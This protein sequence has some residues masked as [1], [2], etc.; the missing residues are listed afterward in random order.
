M[1]Y[2]TVPKRNYC[3]NSSVRPVKF[4]RKIFYS[5]HIER[6]ISKSRTITCVLEKIKDTISRI[7]LSLF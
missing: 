2:E 1:A 3:K 7:S 6:F 5:M 4:Y